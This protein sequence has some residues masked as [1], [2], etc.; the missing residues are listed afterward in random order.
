MV[1]AW[2]SSTKMASD[3]NST[4]ET[5]RRILASVSLRFFAD[6]DGRTDLAE[7]VHPALP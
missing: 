6:D 3:D 5:V 7:A 2:T 1:Q 4:P